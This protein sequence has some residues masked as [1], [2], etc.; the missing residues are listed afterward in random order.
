[1][2]TP[3][4]GR[5]EVKDLPGNEGQS[6]HMDMVPC[7][8]GALALERINDIDNIRAKSGNMQGKL[9]GRMKRDLEEL[10]SVVRAL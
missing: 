7:D 3:I 1:M 5:A 2:G 6:K 8:L 10:R 9:N 4:N